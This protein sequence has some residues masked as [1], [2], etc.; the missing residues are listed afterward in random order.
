MTSPAVHKSYLKSALVAPDA[1]VRSVQNEDKR[2][3]ERVQILGELR[4]DMK[5]FQPMHV[6]EISRTG[7]TI[8]TLFPLQVESLHDVR[9]SLGDTSVVIKG[10][11]V[12]SNVSDI[13]QGAV[14]Y[15]AGLELVDPSPSVS[16]TIE[17]FLGSVKSDRHGV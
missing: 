15:R 17:D 7:V 2:T 5:V 4:G 3:A 14:L 10:R 16:R 9:L 12:H 8:E 11:V 6:R 1:I 13:E